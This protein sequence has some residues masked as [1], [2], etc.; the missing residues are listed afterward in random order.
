MVI[1]IIASPSANAGNDIFVCSNNAQVQLG[2]S[3]SGAGGGQWSGG[4]G[5]FTPSIASLNAIYTPTAAEIAAGTLTLT[6]TTIG[7]GNCVP[8]SDQVLITFTASPTAN[9]GVDGVRCANNASIQLNGSVTVANGGTWS[10]AG[11]TFTPNANALNAVYTPSAGELAAGQVTLT[12]TTTGNNGCTAVSDDVSYTFTPAPTA[13]AGA[14][15]CGLC[16]QRIGG[17]EW[18]DH[19]GNGC[20][21]GAVE[22]ERSRRTTARSMR[23]TCRAHRRSL[24]GTVTLTLT[25]VGNGTCNPVNDQMVITINPSPIVD[26]G[27]PLTSCAN[28]AAV[29]LSGAVQNATGGIWSGAGTFT[30]SAT[31][32]SATYTPSNA[33]IAAGTAT[34]TLTS[35]GNGLCNAVSSQVVLTITAAPIVEAGANQ[36]LCANNA[37]A[38]LGGQVTNA[39]GG[40]WSGGVGTFAP[41]ASTLNAAY[42][43]SAAEVASGSL[44]LFL[45]S[46]GNGGCLSSR[47]SVQLQFTPAP[48]VNAGPDVH[49]CAN[50]TQINLNGAVTIATGGIWS[51]GNG[52][53]TPANTALNASLQP[54]RSGDRKRPVHLGAQHDGQRQLHAWCAIACW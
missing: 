11:G 54:D 39:T 9:A 2:G 45:T 18:R 43:P 7:N 15:A 35:T 30:P 12:L 42:T 10:G 48:T 23:P 37:V 13:N 27:T 17:V 19:G 22:Q 16:E 46:T 29:A 38:Q 6:L 44:W 51:G 47:D 40:T 26:A 4:A 8:V 32:L 31:N 28:N 53:F 25:T 33:E 34:I 49:I 24:A 14:D 41:N 1:T 3:V 21:C 50:T 5:T 52:A 36:V 20:D